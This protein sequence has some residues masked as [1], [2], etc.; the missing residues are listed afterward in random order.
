MSPGPETAFQEATGSVPSATSANRRL[1]QINLSK[2]KS[3]LESRAGPR[4]MLMNQ[5]LRGKFREGFWNGVLLMP[6]C[7]R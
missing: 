2:T 4:S 1:A 5:E 7:P 3:F 6:V